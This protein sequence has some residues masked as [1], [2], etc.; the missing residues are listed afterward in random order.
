M[1]G[2]IRTVKKIENIQ[3]YVLIRELPILFINDRKVEVEKLR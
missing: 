3:E 2:A 1:A